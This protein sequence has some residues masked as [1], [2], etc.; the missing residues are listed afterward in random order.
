MDNFIYTD[1]L[2]PGSPF[3]RPEGF[4][5]YSRLIRFL[6]KEYAL[7]NYQ[8]IMSPDIWKSKLWMISGHYENYKDNMFFIEDSE[9]SN[10]E[11]LSIR[12][13]NCPSHCR[14]FASKPKHHSE[15]PLRY[16]EFGTL[17]RNELEGSL[18]GLFRVRKFRQ[19]DAHIFCS[20]SHISQEIESFLML[21]DKIYSL[22]GF[23][24]SLEL[25][26][27]PEKSIGSDELWEEAEHVLKYELDKFC[28]LKNKEWKLEKGEGAFYGPKIDV[29][30]QDSLGRNHQCGTIQL[31]FNLPE[32][33]DL[34]YIDSQNEKKRPVILHRAV[35]GSLERFMG[36]LFDNFKVSPNLIKMPFW[37]S[38]R[39]FLICSLYKKNVTP[40]VS[41]SIKD[42]VMKFKQE[43]LNSNWEINVDCDVSDTHIKKKLKDGWLSGYHYI[44]VV[45]PKEVDNQ[46]IAINGG[47]NI[48]Y[49]KRLEDVINIYNN[50]NLI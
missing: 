45:G 25:S 32:R 40:E 29:H 24:Y 13:M 17:H 41:A 39:Q 14:L 12:C 23:K 19:D 7:G 33:F 6:R 36:I 48:D 21:L 3:F 34:W 1:E 42:Y 4:Y 9:K 49:D 44:L 11:Q 46:T 8:E 28:V 37:L 22:F 10:E 27:R 18:R 5:I 2:S 50:S 20:R 35:L 30:L 43:L 26:T 38:K 15:L 31:D 16:S 47:G